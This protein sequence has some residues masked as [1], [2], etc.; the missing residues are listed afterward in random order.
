MNIA[1]AWRIQMHQIMLKFVFKLENNTTL[2]AI[3]K[4]FMVTLPIVFIGSI[5]LLILNFPLPIINNFLSSGAGWG[6]NRFLLSIFD[7]TMGFISIYLVLSIS[8]Y[9][10]KTSKID[11]PILHLLATATSLICFMCSFGAVS[12]SLTL[13]Y[14]GPL[15]VF[16]AILSAIIPTHIFLAIC[17]WRMRS[18]HLHTVGEDN[19]LKASLLA[20]FPMIVCIVIFILANLTLT[21]IFNVNNLNELIASVFTSIFGYFD[22]ELASSILFTFLLNLLWFFG[23]HGGNVLQQVSIDSFVPTVSDPN[24]IISKSFLDVFAQMG[25]SGATICLVIAILFVSR[26]SN[27]I[28][29]ASMASPMAIFNINEILVF[30]LPT[31]LNPVMVIPFVV[32]PISSLLISYGATAIGLMP[33]MSEVV[34]WT[35]PIGFSGYLATQSIFGIIVQI[36]ILIVGVLIYIPF[37]RLMETIQFGQEEK[38]LDRLTKQFQKNEK[39]NTPE[40]LLSRLDDLGQIAKILVVQLKSDLSTRN[41]NMHYQPQINENDHIVGAEALLRWSYNGKMIYPP[42]IIALAREDN[43]LDLL[44]WN[45][46]VKVC[47]E[48]KIIQKRTTNDLNISVNIEAQQL[49]NT[50]FIQKAITLAKEYN[51]HHN[52]YF[53]VTEE[54]SLQEFQQ[55]HENIEL[56]REN[57]ILVAIDDFSMG[58]TSLNYLQNNNFKYVKIDGQLVRQIVDNPRCYQI[59]SSIVLLGNSLGYEVI[60]EYVEN[61]EI[62][63][64]LLQLGCKY[65]QGYY[66]SPAIPKEK[67]IEYYNTTKQIYEL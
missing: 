1:V 67:F 49:N 58:Q 22:N 28:R 42:L 60:A 33:I 56:L 6:L 9:Y 63:D 30:G 26:S 14:F 51:V 11:N 3:K 59:I 52:L 7:A 34:N 18:F 21:I 55:I 25:G 24:A 64:L 20:I 8:Y 54:N 44:T 17:S 5:A 2:S 65:F 62:K 16:T 45:I 43:F 29:L 66:Y 32:V 53:E 31:V 48:I 46:L 13:D 39:L 57:G 61:R 12:G 10:A 4:G 41:F 50:G 19:N 47:N 23:I 27:N 15:G 37:V 38:R 35:V 40:L 36:V